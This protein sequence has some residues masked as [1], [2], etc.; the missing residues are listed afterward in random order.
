MTTLEAAQALG[1]AVMCSASVLQGQLTRNLPS[2]I[3]ETFQSLETDG[4][5]ALQFVRSTPGVTTALVGM[6]QLP[7]LRKISKPPRLPPRHGNSIPSCSKTKSR[8]ERYPD[9]RHA[10][11]RLGNN[12][13]I[14]GEIIQVPEDRFELFEHRLRQGR[15]QDGL[16]VGF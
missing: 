3:N 10:A 8:V 14:S 16:D 15:F 12:F 4:Q 9:A 2:I 6:K 5:R 11:V 1:I 7:T 13:S